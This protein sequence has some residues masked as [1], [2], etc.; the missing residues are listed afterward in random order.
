[1]ST[2]R[3][4]P[5]LSLFA[6]NVRRRTAALPNDPTEEELACDWMLSAE[7]R[8]Q[9]FRC[10]GDTNRL[11]FALQLCALRRNGRFLQ[12]EANIPVSIL[13]HLGRQLDLPPRLS[14]QASSR[15]AT[16]LEHERR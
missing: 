15:E 7:D 14:W 12:Y 9:V 5:I 10:R 13:N 8:E 4:V 16:Q 2:D 11:A 1:M 3:V 6:R